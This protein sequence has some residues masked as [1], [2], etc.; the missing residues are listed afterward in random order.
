MPGKP[1]P[2]LF[3]EVGSEVLHAN[4]RAEALKRIAAAPTAAR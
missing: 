4:D 3:L 1:V 2:G